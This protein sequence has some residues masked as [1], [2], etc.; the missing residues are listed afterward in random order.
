MPPR[1]PQKRQNIKCAYQEGRR[2]CPYDA[3]IPITNPPLCRAHQLSVAEAAKPKAPSEMLAGMLVDLLNG[4]TIDRDAAVNAARQVFAD[5]KTAQARARTVPGGWTP[6]PGSWRPPGQ[7]Q[8]DPELRARVMARK[9]MGFAPTEQLTADKIRQ[10][11]RTLAQRY[12]PDL[13]GGSTEKMA[14]IN[15]AADIL[16]RML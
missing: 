10:R 3:A 11:K 8:E 1:A 6:R 15:D 16:M 7:P 13:P 4:E 9:V 2:R 14:M 5:W 12:H